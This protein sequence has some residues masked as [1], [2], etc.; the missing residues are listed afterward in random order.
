MVLGLELYKHYVS[1]V[2]GLWEC[3]LR[4]AALEF[5]VG[6]LQMSKE[7]WFLVYNFGVHYGNSTNV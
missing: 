2:Y 1:L 3:G 6:T 4:F 7:M 5:I